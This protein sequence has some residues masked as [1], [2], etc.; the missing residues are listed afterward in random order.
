MVV[1]SSAP[2][3][4]RTQLVVR[5]QTEEAMPRRAALGLI[6]SGAWYHSAPQSILRRAAPHS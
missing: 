3:Q 4:R 5:A 2:V 1:R 6:A